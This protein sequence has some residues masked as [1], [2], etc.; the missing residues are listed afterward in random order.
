MFRE[1]LIRLVCSLVLRLDLN[2]VFRLEIDRLL[3]PINVI[4]LLLLGKYNIVL[5]YILSVIYTLS[6]G[7]S[8]VLIQLFLSIYNYLQIVTVLFPGRTELIPLKELERAH[9]N[10]LIVQGKLY[11][12]Y[13]RNQGRLVILVVINEGL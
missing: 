8:L 1:L 6:E 7:Y 4:L 3:V 2:Q 13:Y 10:T 9:P 5:S 11:V 12:V